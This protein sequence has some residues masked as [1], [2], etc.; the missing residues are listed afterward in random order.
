MRMNISKPNAIALAVMAVF[1]ALFMGWRT[2]R[3]F[4]PPTIDPMNP[5][6]YLS[7]SQSLKGGTEGATS[8]TSGNPPAIVGGNGVSTP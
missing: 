6:P 8:D 1:L 7:A 5:Q 4:D 3:G 2:T